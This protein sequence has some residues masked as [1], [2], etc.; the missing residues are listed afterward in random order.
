MP[1]LGILIGP[2]LYCD[3]YLVTLTFKS[4]GDVTATYWPVLEY[5]YTLFW[6]EGKR[7][8]EGNGRG[9]ERGGMIGSVN[10][11]ILEVACYQRCYTN[12]HVYNYNY[13]I[14]GYHTQ[15]HRGVVTHW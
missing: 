14:V 1:N 10:E 6:I 9:K 8:A 7:E 15:R 4:G 12:R 3:W 13:S 2:T 11:S 5:L